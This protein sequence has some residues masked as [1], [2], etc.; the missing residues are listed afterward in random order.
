[1]GVETL[2]V[3]GL[4][5][6]FILII[7]LMKKTGRARTP[8]QDKKLFNN[9]GKRLNSKHLEKDTVNIRNK[10]LELF[11]WN[12]EL[13]RPINNIVNKNKKYLFT[14]DT[15]LPKP[16]VKYSMP[17]WSMCL[18]E[19]KSQKNLELLIIPKIVLTGELMKTYYNFTNTL[20]EITFENETVSEQNPKFFKKYSIF[21]NFQAETKKIINKNLT[22]IFTSTKIKHLTI[23]K[24]NNL[25]A[26]YSVGALLKVEDFIKLNKTAIDII[27]VIDNQKQH[28]P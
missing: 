8:A 1:M 17:S 27:T 2:L 18:T 4:I 14:L 16:Y 9:L 15:Y 20:Q 13:L 25:N 7:Y 19:E 12:S 3:I 28:L 26:I 5:L 10:V 21:S 23:H 11:S 6:F 24:K 22:E